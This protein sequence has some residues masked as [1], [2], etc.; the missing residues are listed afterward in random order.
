VLKYRVPHGSQQNVSTSCPMH[1]EFLR[2]IFLQD[3]RETEATAAGMS[4]QNYQTDAF[5]FKRAAFLQSLKSKI[6]QSGG[7]EDQPQ[8]PGLWHSGSPSARSFSRS[9]STSP[10]SFA[11]YPSP[12]RSLARDGQTSP[13][14]PRLV[15]SRSTCPP[16]S[17]SPH[18]NSLLIGTA[19]IN[20]HSESAAATAR[21][22]SSGGP[23]RGI[24]GPG[25][26]VEC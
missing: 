16:L 17:P 20:I 23:G 25:W 19:V 5:R 14:R 11:Q 13:H 1:G 6:L 8:Y 22:R 4:S 2:L 10:P 21:G 3:H 24:P 12:P 9:P 7:V 18:A 15:V 26:C